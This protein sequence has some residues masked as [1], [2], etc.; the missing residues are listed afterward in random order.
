ML[1]QGQRPTR[2]AGSDLEQQ[3]DV[4]RRE[5]ERKAGPGWCLGDRDTVMTPGSRCRVD[6]AGGSS[7]GGEPSGGGSP[8]LLALRSLQG[9]PGSRALGAELTPLH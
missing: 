2:G 1:A 7:G 9:R 3:G 5:Q 4:A 8:P 6:R